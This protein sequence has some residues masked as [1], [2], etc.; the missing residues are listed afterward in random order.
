MW[1]FDRNFF[2]QA[3]GI[4]FCSEWSRNIFFFI[5]KTKS[6]STQIA[7]ISNENCVGFCN[8]IIKINNTSICCR[9]FSTERKK[10]RMKKKKKQN[11]YGINWNR[12]CSWVVHE[13]MRKN[14][15]WINCR[16]YVQMENVIEQNFQFSFFFVSCTCVRPK[17]DW[18]LFGAAVFHID[19][20]HC[21]LHLTSITM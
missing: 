6:Y 1:K 4:R 8:L 13:F 10:D 18:A 5:C 20:F 12:L 14:I 3:R 16:I 15:L 21:T 19:S 11:E 9:T 7:F 2:F 17:I